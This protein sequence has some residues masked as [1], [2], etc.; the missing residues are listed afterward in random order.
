MADLESLHKRILKYAEIS[1]KV[2]D[3]DVLIL[4][5]IPDAVRKE[6]KREL[7]QLN[8]V[9][10]A[11]KA[12]MYVEIENLPQELR[13]PYKDVLNAARGA[14]EKESFEKYFNNALKEME[15][16]RGKQAAEKNQERDYL[17]MQFM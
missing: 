12:G 2:N 6:D 16:D 14:R 4:N 3:R 11:E 10:K 9:L 8:D 7:K 15:K 17:L 5:Y 1:V 13:R